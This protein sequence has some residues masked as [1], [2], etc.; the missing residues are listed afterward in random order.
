MIR[1]TYRKLTL[2][3]RISRLER[4]LA[5]KRIT[6]K[7]ESASSFESNFDKVGARDR[8][9]Q[10]AKEFA[11]VTGMADF[12]LDDTVEVIS[13]PLNG[14][15]TIDQ[16]DEIS[17]DPNSRFVFRYSNSKFTIY[18]IPTDNTVE[19]LNDDNLAIDPATGMPVDYDVDTPQ[20]GAF[21]MSVWAKSKKIRGARSARAI[22][23]NDREVSRFIAA[24]NNFSP[25]VIAGLIDNGADV[26]TQTKDGT[27]AL[28][29]AIMQGNYQVVEYLL[30]SGADPNL[31]NNR[32]WTP[33]KIA[34]VYQKNH[35]HDIV[36]T[37]ISYG[38][39]E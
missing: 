24:A 34:N 28:I 8:A 18:V 23:A 36:G 35:P 11:R 15:L 22:S 16:V 10:M 17:E 3:E 19:L 2:E 25:S 29:T 31:A 26:N 7:F 4:A 32:G 21:P 5:Q 37:L 14:W 1:R 38:A 13:S 27:T 9:D 39:H 12:S 20:D 33:L 6:R 30:E